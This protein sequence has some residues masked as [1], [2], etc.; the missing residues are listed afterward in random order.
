MNI[1]NLYEKLAVSTNDSISTLL[2]SF[3]EVENALKSILETREKSHE[4]EPIS[5]FMQ[6]LEMH[7]K[8]L[9][10]FAKKN[11]EL[12]NS[13]YELQEWLVTKNI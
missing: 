13:T 7:E 10:F 9:L 12:I 5:G 1:T 8:D 6:S 2:S 3:L 4:N 11:L